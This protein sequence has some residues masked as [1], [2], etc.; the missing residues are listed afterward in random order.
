MDKGAVAAARERAAEAGDSGAAGQRA[1][2][3]TFSKSATNF[4]AACKQGWC[5]RTNLHTRTVHAALASP[6]DETAAAS[7]QPPRFTFVEL[8]AGIGGFRL[9]LEALGGRCVFACEYCRFASATYLNNWPGAR[10]A[11]DIRRVAA[12]QVP[13][14]DVLAA[15]FPCQ[16]FSN[17]GRQQGFDDERGQLFFE[18]VRIAAGCRP[19]AL[20]LENVR[21]LLECDA[22]MR[23]VETALAA[24]GYPRLHVRLFDAASLVPQRRRRVF[25]VAF[26][27]AA[28]RDV[29]SWPPVAR[30][31]R[32]AADVLEA[33]V[34]GGDHGDDAAL[35]A[36]ELPD[37][38]WSKVSGSAYYERYPGA[39]LLADGALAQ[40]L[41]CTYKRGWL[42][43]SQFV[44]TGGGRNPRFYSA[45]E[46]ARLMGFPETYALPLADGMAHRQ[47]GNAVVPPIVGAIAAALI[48]ALEAS[49][50]YGDDAPALDRAARRAACEAVAISLELSAASS[51]VDRMPSHC[52]LPPAAAAALALAEGRGGAAMG[53]AEDEAVGA[54]ASAQTSRRGAED[55]ASG[56][57]FQDPIERNWHGPVPLAHAV[58]AARRGCAAGS[59]RLEADGVA[60][61]QTMP[62][63][64]PAI[65]HAIASEITRRYGMARAM[66]ELQ[67]VD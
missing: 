27:E 18:L 42:L 3:R 14:H 25:I 41:Q 40:T 67:T 17:A 21:G 50:A 23:R 52:W 47:L 43:Y 48:G 32:S 1:R 55:G 4:G 59:P 34:G 10:V 56:A 64:T 31:V 28:P 65:K 61:R 15:G 26:R 62:D 5:T 19:R 66:V 20:L 12:A 6:M 13:P 45:R 39:R 24:A 22:T 30:L 44:P 58:A 63:A 38:K 11:G 57:D 16:S 46:C 37:Q 51:P 9:A 29:F 36:L 33:S 53:G 54:A 35:A 60:P 49:A 8:F 2:R 7:A